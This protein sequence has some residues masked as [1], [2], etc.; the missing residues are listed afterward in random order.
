MKTLTF[1]MIIIVCTYL[2]SCNEQSTKPPTKII[3]EQ[4]SMLKII[5]EQ[6]SLVIISKDSLKART[7]H[8]D[9][10]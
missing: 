4:D 7:V 3:M 6:D 2:S 10:K 9:T 1:L 8:S 5:D